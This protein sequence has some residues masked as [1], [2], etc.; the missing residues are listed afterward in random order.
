MYRF[1]E[2]GRS[3]GYRRVK[4]SDVEMVSS[5]ALDTEVDTADLEAD[6]STGLS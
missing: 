2:R 1:D 3:M 4:Q 6:R 5:L